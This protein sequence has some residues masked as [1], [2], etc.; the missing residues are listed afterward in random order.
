M[1]MLED[2]SVRSGINNDR[3]VYLLFLFFSA[4]AFPLSQ[5]S[6]QSIIQKIATVHTHPSKN[7]TLVMVQDCYYYN[8]SMRL[9]MLV[10][11]VIVGSSIYYREYKHTVENKHRT[12]DRARGQFKSNPIIIFCAW[13]GYELDWA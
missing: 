12:L 10:I 1:V 2:L 4:L 3:I 7:N 13:I 9:M 8:D 6:P 11:P 5:E